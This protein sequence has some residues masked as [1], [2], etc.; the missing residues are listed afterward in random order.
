M[1]HIRANV[2]PEGILY[3]WRDVE[4]QELTN[5]VNARP[6]YRRRDHNVL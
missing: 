5:R 3:G 6:E 4:I 1:F 2:G